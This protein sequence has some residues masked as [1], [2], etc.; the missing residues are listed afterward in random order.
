M[1]AGDAVEYRVGRR[2]RRATVIGGVDSNYVELKDS[3]SGRRVFIH[4]DDIYAIAA[5][6][7]GLNES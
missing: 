2:K 1:K 4:Q 6:K 5:E 3:E 7:R